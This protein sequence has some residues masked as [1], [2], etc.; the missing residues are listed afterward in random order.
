MLCAYLAPVLAQPFNIEYDYLKKQWHNTGQLE[1]LKYGDYYTVKVS[2]INTYCNNVTVNGESSFDTSEALPIGSIAA[3]FDIG[4]IGTLLSTLPSISRSIIAISESQTEASEVLAQIHKVENSIIAEIGATTDI[5]TASLGNLNQLLTKIKTFAVFMMN[6]MS[7][8]TSKKEL[9]KLK[10]DVH[11]AVQ[12]VDYWQVHV[13]EWLKEATNYD[14]NKSYKSS[15]LV[16]ASMRKDTTDI[17]ATL[18]EWVAK[19]ANLKRNKKLKGRPGREELASRISNEITAPLLHIYKVLGDENIQAILA[20]IVRTQTLCEIEDIQQKSDALSLIAPKLNPIIEQIEAWEASLRWND[21]DALN[22]IVPT[23]LPNYAGEVLNTMRQ[24]YRKARRE[25]IANRKSWTRRSIALLKDCHN[26][27]EHQKAA[28]E[29]TIAYDA[30]I[31]TCDQHIQK[32]NDTIRVELDTRLQQI[33]LSKPGSFISSPIEHY[34]DFGQIE[35]TIVPSGRCASI[36]DKEIITKNYPTPPQSKVS[37]TYGIHL[38]TLYDDI[39]STATSAAIDE[40]SSVSATLEKNSRVELGSSI[41]AGIALTDY[42]G[43]QVGLAIGPGI[44]FTN[45]ARFRLLSGLTFAKGKKHRISGGLGLISGHVNRLSDA[46]NI[47]EPLPRTVTP[48]TVSKLRSGLYLQ[49]GYQY[50]LNMRQ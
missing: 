29:L 18:S 49:V 40:G 15:T 22:S 7:G 24:E 26:C 27:T 16:N 6:R 32:L 45:P 19:Q 4:S 10:E 47:N 11:E 42:K 13:S 35:I 41:M 14:C 31:K 5:Q 25:L 50:R 43:L 30:L 17:L 44:S 9:E 33:S 20:N 34:G 28:S 2:N 36:T 12:K 38:S 1:S 39:V 21:R 23:R 3:L 37:L 8:N 48:L 46:V